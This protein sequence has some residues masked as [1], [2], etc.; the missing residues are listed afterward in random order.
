M[1]PGPLL[2]ARY[3]YPPNSMGYCGP[4]DSG[5]L[6]EYAGNGVVDRGLAAIAHRFLGAWPYLSLI[7]A[8]SGRQPL[9]TDVVEAYWVGN[10]LLRNVPGALLAAHLSDR[11]GRGLAAARTDPVQLALL[12]GRPH[13]NFHVFAVYPWTGLLRAGPAAEP[14]RVL[15]SCR[16]SWGTVTAVDGEMADVRVRPLLYD[17]GRLRLGE[18]AVQRMLTGSRG[19]RLA[20]DVQ[21]GDVVSLHWNWICDVLSDTQASELCKATMRVFRLVNHALGRPSV[22]SALEPVIRPA[23]G[24]SVRGSGTFVPSAAGTA[25]YVM[26]TQGDASASRGA[27]DG[28]A[29]GPD[30]SLADP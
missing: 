25:R 19:Y 23:V 3:A 13:H 30:V 16:I 26:K 4:G 9:D 1:T 28:G 22:G 29:A 2:F 12:G 24:L 5:E 18:P 21:P 15:N 14:L 27:D 7:A 8:A 11:F 6:L 10:Q 17:H 20:Y